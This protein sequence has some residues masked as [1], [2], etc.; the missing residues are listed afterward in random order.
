MKKNYKLIVGNNI[1]SEDGKKIKYTATMPFTI[2][3]KVASLGLGQNE[4]ESVNNDKSYEWYITQDNTGKY[5]SVNSGP[6]AV[7]MAMKWKDSSLEKKVADIRDTYE[8]SGA[9]WT[10][11]TISSY[12][13]SA[14]VSYTSC[15]DISEDSLKKQL[16][17]GNIIIANLNPQYINYN[18]SSESKIGRFHVVD[19]NT[20]TVVIKGYNVVDGKTYFQIYDSFNDTQNYSDGSSKGKNNYYAAS[21]VLDSLKAESVY[22]I[23]INK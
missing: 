8:N 18:S 5:A 3:S 13:T 2:K 15:T 22:P 17:S 16:K 21:E 12:L 20:Y 23:V 11:S 10:I 4:T 6:A 19:G 14:K 1:E 7:D 9:A